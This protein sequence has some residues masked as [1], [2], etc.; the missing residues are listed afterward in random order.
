VT[1]DQDV[2]R[3]GEKGRQTDDSAKPIEAKKS[4]LSSCSWE[5]CRVPP[6][7]IRASGFCISHEPGG[8]AHHRAV[9]KGAESTMRRRFKGV[10]PQ[11]TAD[12]D[13]SSRKSILAYL[14]DRGGRQERGEL[15]PAVIPYKLAELARSLHA[16][17]ALEKL[18][19]IEQL[20][21]ARL[22]G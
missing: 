18:D 15:N 5:G 10:M 21:R 19:G 7:F 8:E 14:Q 2:S 12:P 9:S 13:W 17:E 20:I 6:K 22:N 1:E 16:D 3:R 4:L 11:G